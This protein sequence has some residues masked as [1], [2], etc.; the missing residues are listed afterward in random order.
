MKPLLSTRPASSRL[1]M[2]V[3]VLAFLQFGALGS[4]LLQWG[5]ISRL[6]AQ[7]RVY[8]HTEVGE[9]HTLQKID[10]RHKTPEVIQAFTLKA[11][12]LLY[13]WPGSQPNHFGQ[14]KTDTGVDVDVGDEVF[15]VPTHV[16]QAIFLIIPGFREALLKRIDQVLP[17]DYFSGSVEVLL[18]VDEITLPKEIEPGRYELIVVG[19]R[20]TV[21]N[22]LLPGQ[23]E[24]FNKVVTVETSHLSAIPIGETQLARQVFGV[25]SAGLV[26]VD[27]HDMSFEEQ[28]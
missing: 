14:I 19:N 20:Y 23:R 4:S 22:G 26:I 24:A 13:S 6:L 9:I 2:L 5:A 18:V 11:L 15:K 3:T 28:Q 8:L 27:I 21:H 25:R 10:P 16:A 7:D 12:M 1:P 17:S